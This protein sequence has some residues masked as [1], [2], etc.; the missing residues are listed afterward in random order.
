MEG[1]HLERDG[2]RATVTLDRPATK[3]AITVDMWGGL[4]DAFGSL[5]EDRDVRVVIVT[6]ANG[7]FCSGA[8]LSG[9]AERADGPDMLLLDA[10]GAAATALH[11]LPVPTIAK[12]DG[13]AV[14][15]GVNLALLCD[16][17]VASDRARFSEIFVRR[18]LSLD[19]GGSWVVPRLVGMRQAKQLALLGDI[20]GAGEAERIGLINRA[21][22][23]DELDGAVD[24]LAARLERGAGMAMAAVK[25]QLHNTW[26][27]TFEEAVAA[28]IEAQARNFA[29]GD[30]AEAA[31]A[32]IDKR[33]PNFG[34][35]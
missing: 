9:V 14:G 29:G 34:S 23:V 26:D 16:F 7:E 2:S 19:F 28:E 18:A 15:A 25:D 13:V 11:R 21:V 20:V 27:R 1:L 6:G 24:E 17:V 8:D 35:R 31:Q 30:A 10:L 32:F 3:N 12:V 5:A 22:P 4:A 33:E